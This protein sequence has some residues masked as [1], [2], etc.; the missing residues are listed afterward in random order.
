MFVKFIKKKLIRLGN[1][2][3]ILKLWYYYHFIF[4][5]KKLGNIGL[6]FSSKKTRFQIVQNIIEKKNYQK[7]LE[8]GCFDD[9]LFNH[10]SCK[11]KLV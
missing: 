1:S 11:K 2:S 5:D 4:H 6:D 7:Y 9:E 8:I 3:N 10:V